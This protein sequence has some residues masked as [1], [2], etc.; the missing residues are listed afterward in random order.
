MR[1]NLNFKYGCQVMF[2]AGM[3]SA[4]VG[5]MQ[6]AQAFDS[7]WHHHSAVAAGNGPGSE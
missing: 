4:L 5:T 3:L 6:I 1:G 2:L 7:R